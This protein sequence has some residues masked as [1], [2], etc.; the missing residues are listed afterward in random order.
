MRNFV[1]NLIP[2]LLKLYI[3]CDYALKL[4][5]WLGYTPKNKFC[6]FFL[7]FELSHFSDIFTMKVRYLV[8]AT[9]PTLSC[10]LKTKNNFT[11]VLDML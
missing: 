3:R 1:Y 10:H 2:I 5:I 6:H 9:A 4:C 11:G 7:Q 8:S